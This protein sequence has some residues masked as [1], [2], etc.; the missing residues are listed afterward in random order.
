MYSRIYGWFCSFSFG[1]NS[2]SRKLSSLIVFVV[3]CCVF[4]AVLGLDVFEMISSS[5]GEGE[6]IIYWLFLEVI[7]RFHSS[8]LVLVSNFLVASWHC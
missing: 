3:V 4:V 7:A 6:S 2:V 8:E 1:S 5:I